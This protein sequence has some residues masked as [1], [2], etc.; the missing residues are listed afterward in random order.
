MRYQ[1]RMMMGA[2]VMVGRGEMTR[3]MVSR[4]LLKEENVKFPLIAPS[5][6]LFLKDLDLT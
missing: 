4:A 3:E 5:S 1:I 6:G 2:L